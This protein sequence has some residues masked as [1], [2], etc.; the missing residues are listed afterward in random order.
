MTKQLSLIVFSLRRPNH[1]RWLFPT[2]KSDTDILQNIHSDKLRKHLVHTDDLIDKYQIKITKEVLTKKTYLQWLT[3]Y[4]EVIKSKSFTTFATDNWFNEKMKQGKSVELMSFFQNDI[5]IGTKVYTLKENNV[6]ASFKTTVSESISFTK[7]ISFGAVMDYHFLREL[8]KR[9]ITNVNFGKS[10]NQFGVD[11]SLGLLEYK[12]KFGMIPKYNIDD[13]L[14]DIVSVNEAHLTM[15]FCLSSDNELSL[16]I[17]GT[18]KLFA[19]VNIFQY[20]PKTKYEFHKI[21]Y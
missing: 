14:S 19:E 7:K 13:G 5:L 4:N 15:S 8:C 20:L 3:H 16:Y 11:N 17:F 10:R 21:V 9:N 18:E 2:F 6:I 12:L 1:I